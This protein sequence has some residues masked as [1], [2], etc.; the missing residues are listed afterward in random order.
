MND[1]LAGGYEGDGS[2]IAPVY[3]D[4][5]DGVAVTPMPYIQ[6]DISKA[7]EPGQAG[8]CGPLRRLDC[9][10]PSG[11]PFPEGK[12]AGN[13]CGRHTE[14]CRYLQDIGLQTSLPVHQL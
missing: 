2:D 6:L 5:A 3:I 14:Y 10:G 1:L 12:D 4:M 11:S 13:Q 8:F 9:S 7:D